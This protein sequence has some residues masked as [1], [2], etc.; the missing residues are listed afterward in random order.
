MC[1]KAAPQIDLVSQMLNLILRCI[2]LNGSLAIHTVTLCIRK[3]KSERHRVPEIERDPWIPRDPWDPVVDSNRRE[4]M[5]QNVQTR[6]IF[7]G[8]WLVVGVFFHIW[9][10]FL[11][12]KGM[13]IIF[14][15]NWFISD[16]GL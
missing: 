6:R 4:A 12:L 13:E 9:K 7:V 14:S 11:F 1:L 15:Q 16:K 10:K 2:V 5:R 3:R 8:V